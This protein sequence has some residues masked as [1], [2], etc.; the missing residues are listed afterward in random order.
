MSAPT[1]EPHV[2]DPRW[3]SPATHALTDDTHIAMDAHIDAD[4]AD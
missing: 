1:V 4:Q 2:L 3:V